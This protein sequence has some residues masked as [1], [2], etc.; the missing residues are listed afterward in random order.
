[1]MFDFTHVKNSLANGASDGMYGELLSSITN[2]LTVSSNMSSVGCMRWTQTFTA[3]T[4]S[5]T[6]YV[7]LT[8]ATLNGTVL[9]KRIIFVLAY[10]LTPYHHHLQ[11]K[12]W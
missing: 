11:C 7:V 4:L 3:P 6:V 1:M 2:K 5:S 8:N 12:W 10:M 9:Y